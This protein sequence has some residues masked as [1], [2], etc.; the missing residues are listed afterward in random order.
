MSLWR[1][2][3]CD[4]SV[5]R[6]VSLASETGMESSVSSGRNGKVIR[7]P[8]HITTRSMPV[9]IVPSVRVTVPLASGPE[10]GS[11]DEMPATRSVPSGKKPSGR[12]NSPPRED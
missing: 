3:Y 4:P 5:T 8:V 7:Y 11:K 6:T 1:L 10:G 12:S 9:R 2:W